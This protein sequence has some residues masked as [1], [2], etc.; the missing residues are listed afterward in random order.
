VRAFLIAGAARVLASLWPVDD[1][2]TVSFMAHF[3]RALS[4][5]ASPAAALGRAQ[6]EVMREHAH[7][8]YWAAFQ[9]YG[10]W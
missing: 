4:R 3:H 8:F 5:G 10:R 6:A 2:T 1:A 7:P 9:L